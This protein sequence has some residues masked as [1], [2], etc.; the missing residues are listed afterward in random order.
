LKLCKQV[1]PNPVELEPRGKIVFRVIY[2]N[3]PRACK[4]LQKWAP[5]LSI[6][7]KHQSTNHAELTG[8][9]DSQRH[10]STTGRMPTP[11]Q[12]PPAEPLSTSSY[13]PTLLRAR[14]VV[15]ELVKLDVRARTTSF[16]AGRSCYD[17]RTCYIR[18]CATFLWD[19][20]AG[21]R[22]THEHVDGSKLVY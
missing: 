13:Q 18:A 20:P 14:T 16:M 9:C 3:G 15:Y 22:A 10:R 17:A 21:G 4:K 5:K 7:T 6:N 8:E 19:R 11:H 1:E 2:R 12:H